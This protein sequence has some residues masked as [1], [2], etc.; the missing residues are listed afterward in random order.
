MVAYRRLAFV[1]TIA[2]FILIFVGGLVRVA[3]AGMGCPDWPRCFGRWI[4]PL[5]AAD[6]PAHISAAKFNVVLAWIEYVNRLMG[7]SLGLFILATAILA[8]RYHRRVARIFWPSL[9]ALALVAFEGWLGSMVVA[10]ELKPIMVT[11]HMVLALVIASLLAYATLEAYYL[12]DTG[13]RGSSAYPARASVWTASLWGLTIAQVILGTEVRSGAEIAASAY[14]L[15]SSLKWLSQVGA[16][17]HLHMALGVLVLLATLYVS[18]AM[19]KLSERPSLLVRW[20]LGGLIILA[21]AQIILGIAMMVRGLTPLLQ[22]FHLWGAALYIG[23]LLALF[24]AVR[25][26]SEQLVQSATR[27][28]RLVW[29]T[30]AAVAIMAVGAQGVIRQAERS[31]EVPILYDVPSFSFVESS[32][33]PFG[34][35]NLKGKIS[36]V[37]FF[38]TSCRGPCPVMVVRFGELYDKYA[39]SDKVQLVSFT[40]DP[41]V[42][43]LA[44]LREYATTHRVTDNRWLFVRGEG[45]QIRALCE[46]GFKVSGDLPGMHSTKF[47]LVDWQGRIRGYYDYDD[48]DKLDLLEKNVARLASEMP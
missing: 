13:R 40:V 26:S 28:K 2:T 39:H 21:S 3:G 9:G 5:S 42:D 19:F 15:W 36:I 10:T 8:F 30:A 1:S 37:D 20:C 25:K 16:A 6:I 12:S 4:P 44:R 27:A 24:S 34:L 48:S 32:G 14:P 41:E 29:I 31:R 38:F 18:F 47:V 11:A 46:E 17:Y 43:S 35:D 22:L 7:V 33:Q 45:P 23:F